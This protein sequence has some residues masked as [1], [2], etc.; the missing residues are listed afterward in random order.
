MTK[1]LLVLSLLLCL[2]ACT[3]PAFITLAVTNSADG[4]AFSG[5]AE[6]Y[7]SDELQATLVWGEEQVEV[8]SAPDEGFTARIDDGRG[9]ATVEVWCYRG[10][11]EVGYAQVRRSVGS[12][13]VLYVYILPPAETGELLDDTFCETPDTSRGVPLCIDSELF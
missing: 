1:V 13:S 10:D 9:D 5:D 7:C 12:A 2:T 6:T 4:S 3:G 11:A 8:T